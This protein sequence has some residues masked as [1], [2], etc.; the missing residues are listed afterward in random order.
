[1]KVLRVL[2]TTTALLAAGA[3]MADE[4]VV[5]DSYAFDKNQLIPVGVRAEAGTTGYGGALLWQ[6][7]PYVGL[8][9]GYNGGD[10]SWRDDVSVNGTKYDLDMDNNNI[11]L[12]A[13]IRPWG[14]STNRWAQGLYIAA[15]A[16]YLDNDYDLA[17]RIGNGGTLTIDGNN[18]QQ[19]VAGQEGGVRGKMKYEN[20]IAPYVGFGFAPKIN[21]NW[22]VF[23]EVGAYYTGNP[24]VQ[25]TQYNL[26]PVTGNTTLPQ[27]A[28][29]KEANKIR[30]DDKY[31]WLPVGKVGVNFYW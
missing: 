11:Y 2:V 15:G 22:G 13:E 14:A 4:A 20:D 9:L 1:M 6:A 19:A 27:D 29:D 17:K 8:A 21:K 12:N 18:Y 10:V 7:N 5:H 23:G 28:V 24:T 26:A 30:N 3:A 25:L 16:A 31:K